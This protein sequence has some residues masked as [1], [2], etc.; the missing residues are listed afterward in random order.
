MQTHEKPK[1][2]T[3]SGNQTFKFA[4]IHSY[5]NCLK[6]EIHSMAKLIFESKTLNT[7]IPL[8]DYLMS[9]SWNCS[10]GINKEN[11]QNT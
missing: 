8:R 5:K 3:C 7:F 4:A 9:T 1:I 10:L 6:T 2:I 11:K